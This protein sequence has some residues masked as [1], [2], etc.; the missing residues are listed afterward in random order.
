[1]KRQFVALEQPRPVD[2]DAPGRHFTVRATRGER[3]EVGLPIYHL[4]LQVG[5]VTS[6]AIAPTIA[7]SSWTFS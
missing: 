6:V 2:P 7:R 4:G 1:M 5:Q 3:A